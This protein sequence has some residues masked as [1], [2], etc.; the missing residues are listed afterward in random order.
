[1]KNFLVL[2]SLISASLTAQQNPTPTLMYGV[3]VGYHS[4]AIDNFENA[5]DTDS[6]FI[7]NIDVMLNLYDINDEFNILANLSFSGGPASNEENDIE[8]EWSQ[9]FVTYG[10]RLAYVNSET[11][12][13]WIGFGIS[14]GYA[15]QTIDI[16]G[17]DKNTTTFNSAASD[18]F[19]ELG[20]TEQ[21]DD[22]MYLYIIW[23][24]MDSTLDKIKGDAGGSHFIL[25]LGW[26]L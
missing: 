1:M 13:S 2:I 22:E 19:F 7:Y 26:Y 14:E 10:L 24:G 18:N 21:I 9:S 20:M 8:Y 16:D 12:I 3:G 15:E 23:R 17:G 25:G 11:S 4:T 6:W 5:Y